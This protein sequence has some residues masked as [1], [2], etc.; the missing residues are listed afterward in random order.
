[1]K[2]PPQ[3]QGK[4]ERFHQTLEKYLA[5]HKPPRSISAL[6][7]LLDDF[8]EYY[9]TVRPHRAI[10]RRTPER[11]FGSRRKASPSAR[12]FVVPP[13]CR[14]R[15]DK[16]NGGNVTLPYKSTLYHVGVGR[17]HNKKAIL[18]LVKDRDVRILSLEGE[19]IRHLTLDPSR[20]YQPTGAGNRP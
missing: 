11:A 2:P 9:N 3:T 8:V 18:I 19:L 14:V 6:Q 16:V 13:H 1:L 12:P 10:G 4:V 17:R 15:Q 5:A 7:A 20:V